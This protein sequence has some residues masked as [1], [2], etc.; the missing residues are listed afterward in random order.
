M[1]V[2]YGLRL[3]MY[4]AQ[5]PAGFILS[6][7]AVN[8]IKTFHNEENAIKDRYT[9]SYIRTYLL[10]EIHN[11][12][13]SH[14]Y[15]LSNMESYKDHTRKHGITNNVWPKRLACDRVDVCPYI[16]M[17]MIVCTKIDQCSAYTDMDI[18]FVMF[19]LRK[20]EVYDDTGWIPYPICM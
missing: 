3:C 4:V 12:Y 5:H 10:I 9:N 2:L 16:H 19:M 7:R 1:D 20:R 8:H 13:R 11:I 6:C 14:S 17:D 18:C 15:T